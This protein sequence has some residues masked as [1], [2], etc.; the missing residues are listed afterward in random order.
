MNSNSFLNQIQRESKTI[1]EIIAD[2]LR[3]A[4]FFG[5]L[6]AGTRLLQDE[7]AQRFGVSITPVREAIKTLSSEGLITSDPYRGAYVTETNEDEFEIILKLRLAVETIGIEL[8]VKNITVPE[9]EKAEELIKEMENTNN[10]D[11]WFDLNTKFHTFLTETSR[12]KS[13]IQ[14]HS[15]LR[16]L[17]TFYTPTTK[18]SQEQNISESNQQHR[19]LLEACRTRD[20]DKAINIIQQHSSMRYKLAVDKIE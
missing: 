13:V 4:I 7:L 3:S 17:A 19:E 5:E 12:S 9:I 6:P 1:Q 18:K 11:R 8:T 15:F 20:I 10:F 16:N 2:K 14:M